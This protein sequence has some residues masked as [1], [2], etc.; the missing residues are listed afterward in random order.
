MKISSNVSPRIK[1]DL[2]EIESIIS[3]R[4]GKDAKI[5]TPYENFS[6]LEFKQE[7]KVNGFN[8]ESMSIN[9]KNFL[10]NTA[11]GFSIEQPFK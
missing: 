8:E 11:R 5:L 10:N 2:S 1:D 4:D 9:K 6:D 7:P 3:K